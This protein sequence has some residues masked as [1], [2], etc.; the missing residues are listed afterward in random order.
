MRL[1]RSQLLDQKRIK[2]ATKL[3]QIPSLRAV[4]LVLAH[5]TALVYNDFYRCTGHIANRHVVTLKDAHGFLT[6]ILFKK[7][8]GPSGVTRKALISSFLPQT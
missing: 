6:V 1:T 3:G 8:R 4:W 5:Y 7:S 2:K